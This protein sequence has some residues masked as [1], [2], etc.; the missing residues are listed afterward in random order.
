[1]NNKVIVEYSNEK[2]YP[3]IKILNEKN[4]ECLICMCKL[5]KNKIMLT[6]NYCKCFN[7]VLLCELCFI[8]WFK[9]NN[10]CFVCRNLFYNPQIQNKL[11]NYKIDN[12][13]LK[14]KLKKKNFGS[15]II[16]INNIENQINEI[17]TEEN[18]NENEEDISNISSINN[19][20]N[21]QTTIITPEIFFLVLY[22]AL[23]PTF[24]ILI[25]NEA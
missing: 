22:T 3:N 23:I 17:V 15:R 12:I 8:K 21:S 4:E 10:R 13:I 19:N 7:S 5:K 14:N 16:N 25:I 9:I 6:N 20:I 11:I 2:K 1:M 24:V 18:N